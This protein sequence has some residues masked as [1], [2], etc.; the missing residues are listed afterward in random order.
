M[1]ARRPIAL[2]VAAGIV[3][4][5][6]MGLG[7]W[8]VQRLAWKTDLITRVDARVAADPVPAPPPAEWAGL[9]AENAEYRRVSVG[10]EYR[11]DS[12][13][14]VQ[15]VTERGAGFW[16]MTPLVTEDGWT[17]LVNRGFVAADRRDDR[18]LP[19]GP[20]AVTGLLRLSQPDG[21]FLRANDPDAGR[22]YSRD[23]QAIAATLGLPD[24]A[25]YFIDADRAGDAQPIG[26]LTVIAFRNSHLT[27]A[28]T[29][30]AMAGGLL[31]L[32][33]YALRR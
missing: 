7:V 21:A 2:L 29:W 8:Q 17:V 13:V 31:V 33:A 26:G 22:W 19:Q 15:A 1:T 16:V 27:Y 5:V 9:T 18:P 10:G 23:T 4:L 30:F 32:V 28:L 25:P 14:L 12:D 20:Q 24:V 3:F 6:L 11:P